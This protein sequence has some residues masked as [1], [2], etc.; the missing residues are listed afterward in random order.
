MGFV[1][2]DKI[3]LKL[4]TGNACTVNILKTTAFYTFKW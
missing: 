1:W 2:G 3:V 4:D